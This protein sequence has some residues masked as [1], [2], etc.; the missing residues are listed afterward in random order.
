M[1]LAQV[2]RFD[3]RQGVARPKR[4]P[5]EPSACVVLRF[6]SSAALAMMVADD[7]AMPGRGRDP[8]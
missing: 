2:I 7:D 4:K 8:G 6:S 1:Q 3:E 5:Q